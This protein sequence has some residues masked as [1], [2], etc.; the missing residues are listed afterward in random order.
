MLLATLLK[1]IALPYILHGFF[2]HLTLRPFRV[3]DVVHGLS[4]QC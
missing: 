4:L 1:P 2:R 3:L